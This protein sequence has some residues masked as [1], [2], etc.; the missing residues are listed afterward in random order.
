MPLLADAHISN[1]GYLWRYVLTVTFCGVVA[2]KVMDQKTLVKRRSSYK[3]RQERIK[4]S[5]KAS[6]IHTLFY[7]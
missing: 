6:P 2:L 1:L 7:R 5:E 3:V 4:G